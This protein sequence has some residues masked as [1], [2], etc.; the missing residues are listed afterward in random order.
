LRALILAPVWAWL[1]LGVAAPAAV[2]LAMAL[3]TPADSIPPFTLGLDL[4][5]LAAA[6]TDPLYREAL[7]GS[8]TLAALTALAC[9]LLGYPMALAIARAPARRRPL[10]RGLVVLPF[11]T[12]VLLRLTAWIGLLRDEGHLNAALL[13]LGLADAPLPL[14][15]TD[16]ACVI[17]LAYV[18]LPF[19]VL[20]LEARLAAADPALEQAAT[21]LGAG[22]WQVWWRVT[23][24]L[25]LPGVLAGLVLVAVPVAGEVVVPA[26]L[27]APE[28]LTLGR[29][30]WDVFFQERDWPQAAALALVL[31]VLALLPLRWARP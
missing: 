17:G 4:A 30:I 25:S 23:L 18:Y 7:R 2:L 28:T 5:P 10:L 8:L 27:G 15:H 11:L 12:G 1:L 13:A 19:M 22:P 16:V 3:A 24:P 14:L 29:A 20:P 9:L 31:L 26:L 6:L 21:D